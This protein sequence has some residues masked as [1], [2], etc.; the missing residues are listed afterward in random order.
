MIADKADNLAEGKNEATAE[1]DGASCGA[2]SKRKTGVSSRMMSSAFFV[3]FLV[4][5]SL[6]NLGQKTAETTQDEFLYSNVS[7]AGKA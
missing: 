4:S 2:K 3:L 7:W 6:R 1:E 5:H